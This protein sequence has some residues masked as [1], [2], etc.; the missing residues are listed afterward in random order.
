[1]HVETASVAVVSSSVSLNIHEG[2][3]KIL[4]YNTDNTN[5]IT[6]D[7]EA[8]YDVKTFVDGRG[9]S[10]ADVKTR[11]EKARTAVL[12][13]KH[14]CNSKQLSANQ[15]QSENHQYERQDSST[16]RR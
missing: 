14:I 9:R 6:L 16:V 12:H 11:I 7:G 13:L 5:P 2:K 4:K 15:Y 10:D 3:T 1:M 8:L